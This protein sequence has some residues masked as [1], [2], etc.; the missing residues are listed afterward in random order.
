MIKQSHEKKREPQ[1]AELH[2]QKRHGLEG[3]KSLPYGSGQAKNKGSRA[4][5]SP[6]RH[7]YRELYSTTDD[8]HYVINIYRELYSTTDDTH[9][10][11]SIVSYTLQ[12]MTPITS[13][14]SSEAKRSW[15]E[16]AVLPAARP[17]HPSIMPSSL[18]DRVPL[19]SRVLPTQRPPASDLG[20]RR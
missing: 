7:Q 4:S 9:Y 11:I 19:L 14:I 15:H 1:R 13:S 2:T 20:S 5:S 12:Q 16:A 3:R 6:I 10:V 8:T 18:E 17:R